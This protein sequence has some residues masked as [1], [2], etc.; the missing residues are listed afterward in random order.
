MAA[1]SEAA[2]AALKNELTGLITEGDASVA[3]ALNTRIDF[4][5]STLA[6]SFEDRIREAESTLN[7]EIAEGDA[8]VLAFVNEISDTLG[9]EI[10][11]VRIDASAADDALES[12]I[13]KL[14]T[15]AGVYE[16]EI[17]SLK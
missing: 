15:S 14:E 12:R 16:G 13:E 3:S 8:S 4:E 7:E 9:D 2:D 6:G 17:A 10:S 1:V 11:S 5:V